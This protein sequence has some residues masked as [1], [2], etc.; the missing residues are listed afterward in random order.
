M[1]ANDTPYICCCTAYG[2]AAYKRKA[3]SA[4][5][6]DFLTKP[7]SHMELKKLLTLLDRSIS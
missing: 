3:L 5:M 6:D 1:R 4:G 2:E 7:I